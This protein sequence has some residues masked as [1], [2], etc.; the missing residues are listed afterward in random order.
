MKERPIRGK[1]IFIEG[2]IYSL[3]RR[4]DNFG[5]PRCGGE[6]SPQKELAL[7]LLLAKYR[8]MLETLNFE[9]GVCG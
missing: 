7:T 2:Q 3:E 6:N 8:L 4:L 5:P 9:T 1:R